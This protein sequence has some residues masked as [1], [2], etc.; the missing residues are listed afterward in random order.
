MT[1]AGGRRCSEI[2]RISALVLVAILLTP[3]CATQQEIGAAIGAV[4]QAFRAE[5]ESIL[6]QK[7]TRVISAQKTAAFD[8]MR[9]ALG[10]LGMQIELQ[11]PGLGYLT[12][13]APAPR[14]LDLA[15]WSHATE[16]DLP[17][18]REIARAHI[19]MLS[20]FIRFEPEGLQVVINATVLDTRDG[21]E[22]SLTTRLRE[23]APPR[24]GIPRREYPPPTGVRMA[25]DKIWAEFDRE[26][27]RRAS[28]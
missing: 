27:Q 14:P 19:G 21:A 7:G 4:N 24:S 12:V 28:R 6:A 11:D 17:H 22:V 23:I 9:T 10:R 16:A 2:L 13:A 18:L 15:E 3:G 20:D 8:A 26:L 25:L 1:S 5:Y